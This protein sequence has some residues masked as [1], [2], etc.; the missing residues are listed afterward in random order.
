MGPGVR[1]V[2]MVKGKVGERRKT[3][4]RLI[5]GDGDYGDGLVGER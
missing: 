3:R 1:Q 2:L 5:E 4:G